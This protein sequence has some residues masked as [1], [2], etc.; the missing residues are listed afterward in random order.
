[1]RFAFETY[2]YRISTHESGEQLLAAPPEE[3]RVC[4][5]IDH[6]LPGVTGLDAVLMLRERGVDAPAILI[7]TQPSSAT[8]KRAAAAA[9]EIV[10]KPLLGEILAKKVR[11]AFDAY[12][13]PRP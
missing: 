10:E 12:P 8:R 4:I 2:G 7:T 13:P 9:I 6:R 3:C 11:A 5:V 1:M